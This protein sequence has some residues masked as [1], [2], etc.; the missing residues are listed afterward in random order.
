MYVLRELADQPGYAIIKSRRNLT[1]IQK[2]TSKRQ[3][4]EV[5]TFKYGI[6][7]DP[8]RHKFTGAERF[9]VPKAGDCAKAVKTAIVQ[10]QESTMTR[11]FNDD[12]EKGNGKVSGEAEI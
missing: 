7:L 2:I 12:G 1:S 8:D 11:S 9:W 4:P 5:L 6:E 10:L 3:H